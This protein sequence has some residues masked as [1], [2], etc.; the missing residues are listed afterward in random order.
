MY[1]YT[2]LNHGND[3]RP[4]RDIDPQDENSLERKEYTGRSAE[5]A[6]DTL[7]PHGAR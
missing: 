4:E 1:K 2:G 7:Y 6:Y 5:T 3:G